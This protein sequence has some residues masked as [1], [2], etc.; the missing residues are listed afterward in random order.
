MVAQ[1]V[2]KKTKQNAFSITNRLTEKGQ[3]LTE[4][5]MIFVVLL[6]II[7]MHFQL[8]MNY[9]ASSYINYASYMAARTNL[10]AGED[11]ARFVAEQMVGTPGNS[12]F[13]PFAKIEDIEVNPQGVEI[14][15]TS[16]IYVPLIRFPQAEGVEEGGKGL[17][18]KAFTHMGQEP[19]NCEGVINDNGC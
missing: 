14:N 18:L 3:A 10:V 2:L 12:H 9:V 13:G 17:K 6:F 19:K 11:R 16:P 1:K 15:Y 8:S 5:V 7:L 4:F